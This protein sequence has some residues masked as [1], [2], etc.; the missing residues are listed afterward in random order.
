MVKKGFAC[1]GQF[2]AVHATAYQR[3]ADLVFEITDLAAQRRLRRIQF[4]PGC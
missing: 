3:D 2:N 1:G 4:F